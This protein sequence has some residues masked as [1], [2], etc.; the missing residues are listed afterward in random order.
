MLL[1]R[2]R[3]AVKEVAPGCVLAVPNVHRGDVLE[4]MVEQS[5][6]ALARSEGLHRLA[7]GR[8]VEED[9]V[10]GRGARRGVAIVAEVLEQ[11]RDRLPRLPVELLLVEGDR[12][13]ERSADVRRQIGL[14]RVEIEQVEVGRVHFRQIEFPTRPAGRARGPDRPADW[15]RARAAESEFLD[16]RSRLGDGGRLG[17]RRRLV[18][19]RLRE[20]A[21]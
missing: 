4:L 2:H 11:D 3:L 13:F 12:I 21:R 6:E 1:N 16:G 19:L 14:R 15:A 7:Q 9:R 20:R 10:V 8:D 5:E 18:G 17:L